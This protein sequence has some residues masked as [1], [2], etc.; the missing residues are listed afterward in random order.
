ML[1]PKEEFCSCEKCPSRGQIGKGNIIIHDSNRG[2]LQCNICKTTF[3]E[4][5]HTMFH[6]LKTPKDTVILV[7]ILLT[8]G[9]PVNAIVKAFGFDHRT[10]KSWI[11][12]AGL[13][14]EKVH[15]HLIVMPRDHGQIQADELQAK[16]QGFRAWMA[17]AISVP[18]RLW[19]GGVIYKS[20]SKLL[21]RKLLQ[22]VAA[23]CEIGKPLLLTADGLKTY[24]SQA[25][26]CFKVAIPTG[27]QGRP[28][29]ALWKNFV[30]L[31]CVKS[32]S[33]KGKRRICKGVH[34]IICPLQACNFNTIFIKTIL[35][36]TQGKAELVNTAYIERL[37]ASFRSGISA[38]MRKSRYTLKSIE[39][40]HHWMYLYGTVYNFCMVHRS[41]KTTPAQKAG[42]T[43]TVWTVQELLHYKVP[44]PKWKPPVKRGR[45]SKNI[46][47]LVE[48]WLQ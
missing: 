24:A 3:S 1:Q 32:Y 31:Q 35:K 27:K 36:A 9:C 33:Q 22:K 10:V 48:V 30:L 40:L 26:K 15:D 47:E 5:K 13:H 28:Q 37:N 7:I 14:C 46:K 19:L 21:I 38:L 44:C 16:C 18:S 8:F 6:G 4:T 20:R 29:K 2:I 43:N 39:N 12:K 45:M 42:I 17:L 34:R 11:R 23:C 25:L 41:I